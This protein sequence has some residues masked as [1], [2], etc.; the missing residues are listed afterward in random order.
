M[1]VYHK[2][3]DDL[4]DKA[5]AAAA[6]LTA[7]TARFTRSPPVAVVPHLTPASLVLSPMSP[8]HRPGGSEAPRSASGAAYG[9]FK[10]GVDQLLPLPPEHRH[11]SSPDATVAPKGLLM[12]ASHAGGH[13]DKPPGDNAESDRDMLVKKSMKFRIKLP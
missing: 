11:S 10:E 4:E 13:D 9:Q 6:E 8:H 7:N 5:N 3:I 12:K 2:W 1:D